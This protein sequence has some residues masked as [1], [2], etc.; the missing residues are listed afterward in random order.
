MKTTV[1]KIIYGAMFCIALPYLLYLWAYHT[2]PLVQLPIKDIP[3]FSVPLILTGTFF[4]VYS[5]WT[6][7]KKGKGLPMNAFPPE[8]YVTT[9]LYRYFH[10]PIYVGAVLLIFGV[11]LKFESSSGFWLVAPIFTSLTITYVAGYERE[12]ISRAFKDQ[13][14]TTVFDLPQNDSKKAGVTTQLKVFAWIYI[15]WFILY[16]LFLPVES[17][18]GAINSFIIVDEWIP[19]L[20]GSIVIYLFSYIYSLAI[21]FS[22]DTHVRVRQFVHEMAVAMIL[23]FLCYLCV[24]FVADYAYP[25]PDHFFFRLLL[26]DKQWDGV[27]ASF[28][29]FHVIWALMAA[30]Y[31]A[32]KF[33]R[34]RTL[35]YSIS[36]AI[37]VSCLTTKNHS[38]ADILAAGLI[39]IIATHYNAIYK[40]ILALCNRT[41]NSWREWHWGK[42][43]FINHGIYAGL[44]GV[45]G[46]VMMSVFLPHQPGII[47]AIGCAGFAGAALWAQFVEGSPSLLRPFGYY[48]SVLGIALTIFLITSFSSIG[49]WTLL[50]VS[51]M[52]APVIQAIGRFRCL[53]Q[54]CCH[55]KIKTM[56]PGLCFNHEKSRVNKI[57]GLR[58]KQLYPTQLYSIAANL[59]IFLILLR[60]VY[61]SLPASFITGLYLILN[62]ASRFVEESLRGE[63]QTP[64]LLNMRVYQWLALLSIIT[65]CIITCIN[66]TPLPGISWNPWNLLHATLYGLLIAAVYGMD[67]PYSN[68]RF[69]RLTQ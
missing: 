32:F 26:W 3:V 25:S 52:A 11:M 34:A 60:C 19:L 45:A 39:S 7:W 18:A 49:L 67:F 16:E 29:S 28:P 59:V 8:H 53:V 56:G 21:P 9:G 20:P 41:G 24:P 17:S 13:N 65:G 1:R 66:S 27:T 2:A 14:H 31:G 69:S 15:P 51:V 46:F 5:M 22:L 10:H 6:L 37:A 40:G 35:L 54:G 44:A 4:I 43:R 30:R 58:G 12:I 55:G 57:S 42:V 48:G 47:Y 61:E 38:L 36:I 68:I 23:S 33:P 63:L 64:Y 62:G 50:A